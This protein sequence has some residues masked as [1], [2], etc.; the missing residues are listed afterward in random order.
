MSKLHIHGKEGRDLVK[1]WHEPNLKQL[2]HLSKWP[3]RIMLRYKKFPIENL[4][5]LFQNTPNF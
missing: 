2:L 3:N 4:K 1:V 5:L